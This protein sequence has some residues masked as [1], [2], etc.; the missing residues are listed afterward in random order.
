MNSQSSGLTR[1]SIL[2]ESLKSS[3]LNCALGTGA[4]SIARR[5]RGTGWKCWPH[6]E[7]HARPLAPALLIVWMQTV[8]RRLSE[9]SSVLLSVKTTL[10]ACYA[11]DKLHLD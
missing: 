4:K 5:N 10:A 11:S 7:S 8:A 2:L 3:F 9:T 6:F 1:Q